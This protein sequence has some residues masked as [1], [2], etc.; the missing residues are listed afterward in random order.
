MLIKATQNCLPHRKYVIFKFTSL[1]S[2]ARSKICRVTQ[3]FVETGFWNLDLTSS[4]WIYSLLAKLSS[5]P[6]FS[7]PRRPLPLILN[8]NG[9]KNDKKIKRRHYGNKSPIP[10]IE[11]GTSGSHITDSVSLFSPLF[12]QNLSTDFAD[13]Q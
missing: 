9:G 13:F 12:W 8:R 10:E 11:P 1:H 7:L 6:W 3:C 2:T 5:P 4:K